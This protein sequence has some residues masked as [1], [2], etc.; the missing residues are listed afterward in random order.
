MAS[1]LLEATMPT[2]QEMIATF[3]DW[4]E[5]KKVLAEAQPDDLINFYPHIAEWAA[6]CDI[7]DVEDYYNDIVR[8]RKELKVEEGG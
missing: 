7:E 2:R 1:V 4:D 3:V 5:Q 8:W 6:D